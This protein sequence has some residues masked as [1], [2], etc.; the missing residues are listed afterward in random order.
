[1][2][3]PRWLNERE[4]RAW[5]GFLRLY[6]EVR[7]STSRQLQRDAGL[8][9]A[10]YEV[11]VN[12]SEAPAETMRAF[13][14]GRATRWEKS[15]LSHHLTRMEQ[16]GLVERVK[17]PTDSRGSNVVLTAAGRAAIDAAAP[18]HVEHVRSV[19]VDVL[20]P[21]QLDALAD[22]ADTVLAALDAENDAC[23][24]EACD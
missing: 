7:A 17:C 6:N 22:V 18:R 9:E 23:D 3:E 15:R 1:M 8:S 4:A 20:T 19:F 21:E 24:D 11:L 10:D 5:R 2:S 16:R 14:L 13:E 12:L